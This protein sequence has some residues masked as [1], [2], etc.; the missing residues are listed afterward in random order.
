[1]S[2]WT[3]FTG[4]FGLDA[5]IVDKDR[6]KHIGDEIS[7]FISPLPGEPGHEA[8]YKIKLHDRH[9]LHFADVLVSGDLRYIGSLYE[10]EKWLLMIGK[11][12]EE[13]GWD[14]RCGCFYAYVEGGLPAIYYYDIYDDSPYP[15]K[16]IRDFNGVLLQEYKG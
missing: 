5:F 15:W 12:L 16:R 7:R 1:M 2:I 3:H 14:I 11:R 10:I 13:K 9:A 8:I 4:G 6:W